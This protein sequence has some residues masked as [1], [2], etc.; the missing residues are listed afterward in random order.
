ML[1]KEITE[2]LPDAILTA[3]PPTW[4]SGISTLQ[5]L[6]VEHR[7]AIK[8]AVEEYNGLFIDWLE[9][10][11]GRSEVITTGVISADITAGD[12]SFTSTTFLG[13]KNTVQIGTDRV[14]ITSKSGSDPF[15]YAV[16]GVFLNNHTAGDAVTTIGGS[17]L[18]GVGH[19]GGLTGFGN[20]DIWIGS[21]SIHPTIIGNEGF[22]RFIASNIIDKL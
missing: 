4:Y 18:T 17:L 11:I 2:S 20:C 13:D 10:P 16:N 1:F 19:V 9:L 7:D 14:L 8:Q 22:A 6:A 3:T 5:A 15:T 21:D 12:N